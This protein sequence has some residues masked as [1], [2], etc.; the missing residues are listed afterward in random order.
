MPPERALGFIP[1]VRAASQAQRP[2]SSRRDPRRALL[3]APDTLGIYF[4][5]GTMSWPKEGDANE[6]VGEFQKV[7]DTPALFSTVYDK[8]GSYAMPSTLRWLPL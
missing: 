6:G 7:L 4:G 3:V 2:R 8:V 5:F 1:I